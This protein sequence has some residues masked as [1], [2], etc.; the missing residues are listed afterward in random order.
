MCL[1]SGIDV[2]ERHNH[3]LDLYTAIKFNLDIVD[4]ELIIKLSTE[5]IIKKAKIEFSKNIINNSTVEVITKLS[6][7]AAY[8]SVYKKPPIAI[9]A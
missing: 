1:H 2:L 9:M 8:R 5:S 6:G 3:S 7:K 4:N